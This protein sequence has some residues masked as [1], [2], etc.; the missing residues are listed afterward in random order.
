VVIMVCCGGAGCGGSSSSSTTSAVGKNVAQLVCAGARTAATSVLGRAVSLTIADR[1]PANVECLL[2]G[3]GMRLDVVAQQSARAWE[4]WDTTQV[5]QVQ[6]YGA[7][8]NH[9]PAQIPKTVDASGALAA[10]IPA[11]RMMFA[12]NGTQSKGGSYVTVNVSGK[13]HGGAELK[14]AR[15]VTLAALKVAPT[16][17]NLAPPS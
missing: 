7:S 3:S 5:H 14:L 8:A 9:Q 16:G 11:Q 10:W 17:P 12:T 6:A 2:H 15:A 13:R 1:D 4:Q